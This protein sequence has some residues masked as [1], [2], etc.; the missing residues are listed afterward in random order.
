MYD[1]YYLKDIRE[2]LSDYTLF[3][4]RGGLSSGIQIG[5]INYINI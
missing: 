1:I 5:L 4:D 2:Q 3:G